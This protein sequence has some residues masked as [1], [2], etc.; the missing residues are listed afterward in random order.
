MKILALFAILLLAGA[1]LL[2][3]D[4][5]MRLATCL[6]RGT[7]NPDVWTDE[8]WFLVPDVP[9]AGLGP[10]AKWFLRLLGGGVG[11]ILGYGLFRVANR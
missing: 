1:S 3:V 10:N 6:D 2:L 8:F 7:F 9:R 4:G 5:G 11:A